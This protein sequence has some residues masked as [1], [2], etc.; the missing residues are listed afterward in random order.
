MKKNFLKIVLTIGIF[1]GLMFCVR[2]ANVRIPETIPNNGTELY[3]IVYGGF[4]FS[5]VRFTTSTNE[6]IAGK[7][8]LNKIK[9]GTSYAYDSGNNI[10]LSNDWFSAYCL[11]PGLNYP[12]TG[13]AYQMTQH[14]DPELTFISALLVALKNRAD[15]IN[16]LSN[17][18]TRIKGLTFYQMDVTVPAEYMEGS[19]IKYSDIIN[20]LYNDNTGSLTINVGIN[21]LSFSDLTANPPT[22]ITGTEMNE[23]TNRAADGATFTIGLTKD[24]VLYNKYKVTS[25]NTNN[26]ANNW[27]LWIIEH[28][29]PTLSLETMFSNIG[30]SKDVLAQELLTLEG[31]SNSNEDEV[32]TLIENYV[33]ATIQ[34][35]IW[36]AV[37]VKV[38]GAK[39]GSDL[40]GSEE[41]NKIYKYFTKSRDYSKYGTETFNNTLKVTR[42]A[43][44][45]E[46]H[47]ETSDTIM[48]GPYSFTHTL[49]SL[50]KVNLTTN[51]GKIVDATGTEMSSVKDGEKFY[52]LLDKKS[53]DTETKISA[54]TSGGFTFSPASN[55]GRIYYTHDPLTQNVGTGGIIAPMTAETS[56]TIISSPKTGIESVGTVFV[57]SLLVFS[58]GYVLISYRQKSTQL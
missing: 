9:L 40:Q 5:K 35:S 53:V 50:D 3:G 55:R 22:V 39:L 49:L 31:L 28:S 13:I 36:K 8:V 29:Y 43:N 54:T 32:N 4:D 10:Q 45:S 52:V 27:A 25:M 58:L 30:V 2:A 6:T 21:S 48:Y 56:F 14:N 42:P 23:A 47:Q 24:I 20:A 11:N 15:E 1:F 17:V 16:G 46:I 38:D 33:Y 51:Q 44:K 18:L 19:T 41:L 34:Y 57:L 12:E 26:T 37:D 7:S